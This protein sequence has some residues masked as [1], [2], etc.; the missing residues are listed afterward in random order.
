MFLIRI[1][2]TTVGSSTSHNRF[3]GIGLTDTPF[4]TLAEAKTTLN[5]VIRV[6]RRKSARTT[7]VGTD[8]RYYFDYVDSFG[9]TCT[10][11]FSIVQLTH[12]V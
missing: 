7:V 5:Y 9:E 12:C 2:E 8:G 4:A 11:V 10:L 6:D 3:L 1:A